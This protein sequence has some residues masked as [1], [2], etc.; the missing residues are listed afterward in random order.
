MVGFNYNFNFPGP[1]EL[2]FEQNQTMMVNVSEQVVLN[3]TA[4]SSPDPVYNWSIPDTCSS[5]SQTNNGSVMIFTA[6]INDSGEYVCEA[7]NKLESVQINFAINVLCKYLPCKTS[8]NVYGANYIINFSFHVLLHLFTA[9]PVLLMEPDAKIMD[10]EDDEIVLSC[11]IQ[12]AYPPP[13]IIWSIMTDPSEGFIALNEN[14]TGSS[15]YQLH[16]NGSII[17][18]H[19]FLL[20]MGNITLKCLASNLY[21]SAIKK[22]NVWDK[23]TFEQG[24]SNYV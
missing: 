21:G 19:R 20:E 6:D 23:A 3:C 2:L 5:C 7:K 22:I 15:D 24:I 14:T 16:K 13:D 1:P 4:S 18:Y 11:G 8:I 9:K 10:T 17:L 12:H